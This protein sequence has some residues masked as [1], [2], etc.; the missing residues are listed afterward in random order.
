ML[1]WFDKLLT[2]A[3]DSAGGLFNQATQHY[4]QLPFVVGQPEQMRSELATIASLCIRAIAKNANHGDAYVLLA[5]AL[6]TAE[7]YAPDKE[8]CQHLQDRAAGVIK[9]WA[10]SP[11][12]ASRL[13]TK[14]GDIGRQLLQMIREELCRDR[15]LSPVQADQ[16]MAELAASVAPQTLQTESEPQIRAE[17]LGTTATR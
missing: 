10:D 13:G 16:L 15:H 14:N 11:P 12:L 2:P 4:R 3:P 17:I 9:Y 7:T 6:S 1:G 5:N 8:A